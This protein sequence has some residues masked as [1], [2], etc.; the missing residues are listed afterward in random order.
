MASS[1][2]ELLTQE[3][4][5]YANRNRFKSKDKAGAKQLSHFVCNDR[6]SFDFSNDKPEK[7][8]MRSG[9]S[10]F[11]SKRV[12]SASGTSNSN[13]D[14]RASEGPPM[15]EVA[16]RA[17]IGILSGY[18][19]NYKNDASFRKTMREKCSSCLMSGQKNDSDYQILVNLEMGMENIDRLVE[20]QGVKKKK[21]TR[22]KSLRN[23][24]E[25][26]TIVASLNSKTSKE[27]STC[28]IPNS[29]LSA[30]AQLYL[31][32]VYKLEKN[33][34]ISARHLLQVFCDSPFVARTFLLP[35]LWEHLF[36]PHLLHIKIWYTKELEFLS[37]EGHDHEKQK[38]LKALSK[39]YNEKMDKGT[40]LFALYY[41]QWLKAGANEPPIPIIPLPSRPR[42]N[43]PSRRS[44]SDSFTSHTSMNQNLYQAVFGSKLEQKSSSSN[45]QNEV[46]RITWRSEIDENLGGDE[47]NISSTVQKEDRMTSF[48]SFPRKINR[49]QSELLDPRR[50]D[51]FQC[52]SCRNI[53]TEGLIVGNN[54]DNNVSVRKR[55]NLSGDL[56]ESITT[57]CSSGVLSECE[58]AIRMITKAWLNSHGDHALVEA[59][60]NPSVIEAMLEVLFA[61]NEDEILELIIS[62]LA[63]LVGRNAVISQ[64]ILNSDP[65]LVVFVRLLRSTSL[66]LK[67][68]ILLYLSKP[69]AK[70]MLSSEWVPL[71]LRVLEFGDKIQTL[72]TVQ[73]S[74]HKA[75]FYLLDQLLTCFDDDKNLEN[76][77]QVVSLGGLTLLIRRIEK[78]EIHERNK[79]ALIISCCIRAE[80]SCRN[81][82]ADN[83][84]KACLLELIVLD[85]SANFSGSTFSV[86]V[87]LLCLDRRTRISNFLRGLKEGWGGLNT[88][89]I[90]FMYL[91]KAKPEERQLVATVLLILDLMEDPFKG[92]FYREEAIETIVAC[93]NCEM[94]DDRIQERSARALLMLGGR[95]SYTGESVMEK[96]LLQKA[97]FQES[98]FQDSCH[99]KE[100]VVYDSTPHIEE[101]EV[102]SWQERAACAMLKSGNSKKLVSALADSMAN[103]IPCL[104]RASLVTVSWMSNYLH[105]VQDREL[106]KMA[107]S[108]L[109]P[110]LLQSLNYD[111]DSEERVL[112]SYS[113][114][115][116]FKS[117]GGCD[118]AWRH[119]ESLG[120]LQN[121]SLVTW[122]ANK[123]LSKASLHS[124]Q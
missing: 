9:S 98:C 110:Q 66:F 51:Y 12:D 60:S 50:S 94:C 54:T 19:G 100:I 101:E 55:T 123:L 81:F 44:S 35:E 33:D 27:G 86:L 73:C 84:D 114:L 96:W 16:I 91:R 104:A 124:Q 57:L 39:V 115:C 117:S 14:S 76:A 105:L 68:A 59:L 32:I 119:K 10:S 58:F 77:R 102:E 103:G 46:L 53:S 70:Q 108:I 107:S 97:G 34:R 30:C 72:F 5:H 18:I 75:A 4:F 37:S 13:S 83:I 21:Q 122:T 71:V 120:Q 65:Q 17:V 3:S 15:D 109:M 82:L 26:L 22:I 90:L 47:Y 49:N 2:R 41:K 62:I 64:I 116:L 89:H 1:L 61:S 111:R 6:K 42:H 118:V 85:Y 88:M 99:G 106:P 93:L 87:E 48:G 38:K 40:T 112:A 29:H 80:G 52:F 121:L 24:I 113:L 69:Q 92:S 36:L 67:A 25:L 45:D 23:S 8:L 20:D 56:I 63:E 31:A 79:A 74:P 28:G 78:G 7:S 43:R 11:Q 95:F